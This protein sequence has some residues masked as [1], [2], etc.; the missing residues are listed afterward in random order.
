MPLAKRP[1][2]ASAKKPAGTH[3]KAP[4]PRKKPGGKVGGKASAAARADGAP[5]VSTCAKPSDRAIGSLT[6]SEDGVCFIGQALWQGTLGSVQQ[7]VDSKVSE[8]L[9]VID[10]RIA[11][12]AMDRE[13]FKEV[14]CRDGGRLDIRYGMDEAV[15][16]ELAEAGAWMSVVREY[17]GDSAVL[18]FS[19]VVLALGNLDGSDAQGQAW[20]SDGGHLYEHVDLPCHC[21]NVFVPLVDLDASNGPTEF[22]LGSHRLK[23]GPAGGGHCSVL[24]SRCHAGT[25]IVFD[26]RIKH[27]GSP[28]KTPSQRPMLYF[29]YCKPWFIDHQNHR[30]QASIFERAPQAA[31]P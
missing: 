10:E 23:A 4:V 25:A 17:L 22:I 24:S 15:L 7:R 8:I 19:G 30:S 27:R 3:V 26:Y 16:L 9:R 2:Q 31:A 12:D 1:A 5:G 13:Q 28:N 21:L 6:L 14:V 11:D 18:L 29:T 20:H